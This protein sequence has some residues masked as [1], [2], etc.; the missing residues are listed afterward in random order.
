MTEKKLLK[1]V[2]P[3]CDKTIEE[4]THTYI[5][6]GFYKTNFFLDE[7]GKIIRAKQDRAYDRYTVEFD[8]GPE[9][10]KCGE[11]INPNNLNEYVDDWIETLNNDK[12]A[13]IRARMIKR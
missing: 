10:P 9:C 12:K 1:I 3:N 2:C 11:I 5:E 13:E 6:K 4:W 7:D 8:R